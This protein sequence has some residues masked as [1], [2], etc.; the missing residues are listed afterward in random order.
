MLDSH[1][2]LIHHQLNQLDNKTSVSVHTLSR[3][4]LT[5]D[6]LTPYNSLLRI[7][8]HSSNILVLV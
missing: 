3:K 5:M 2:Q 4:L 6:T 8:L 1:T 7:Y